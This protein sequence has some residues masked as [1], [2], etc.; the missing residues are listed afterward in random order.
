MDVIFDLDGVIIDSSVSVINRI[1]EVAKKFNIDVSGRD[2]KGY[3]GYSAEYTF[4]DLYSYNICLETKKIATKEAADLMLKLFWER[5]IEEATVYSGIEKA[6][7]DLIIKYGAVLHV[8]TGR[9][10]NATIALLNHYKLIRYFSGILSSRKKNKGDVI[11][12]LMTNYD[13]N[14]NDCYFIGDRDLDVKAALDNR[15]IPIGALWGFGSREELI[16]SGCEYIAATPST[17][18]DTVLFVE[19]ENDN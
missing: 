9:P 1:K 2:L 3:I 10:L 16:G 5:P 7:Q 17:L 11:S 19:V 15:I 14:M 4:Y 18:I 13:I 12:E 8:V 6:I